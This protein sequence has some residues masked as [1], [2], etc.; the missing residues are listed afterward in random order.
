MK[1]A[2]TLSEG[3]QVRSD[4]RT[5]LKVAFTLAEV[6]ITLAVIGIVAAITIP[7][8]V[9]KYK[10][11]EIETKLKRFYSMAN[12]AIQL[13]EIDNGPKESWDFVTGCSTGYEESCIRAFWDKYLEKYFKYNKVEFVPREDLGVSEDGVVL[14]GLKVSFADGSCLYIGWRGHDYSYYINCGKK[15]E[16]GK[17]AFMFGL[18]PVPT[19][20]TESRYEYYYKKGIVPYVSSEWDG[21]K[22]DLY[23]RTTDYTKIIELNGWK[24]PDDYPV[25]L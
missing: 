18:Y 9:H 1:K 24:I 17:S 15:A 10:K 25:K 7:G 8:I 2:F 12:Q 22:E 6:L 13:S 11:T 20:I 16:L 23:N 21:T 19:Y 3:G 4:N 14:G 5:S